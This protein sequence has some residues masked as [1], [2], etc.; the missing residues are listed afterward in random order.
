M[1]SNIEKYIS[2][3]LV[4]KFLL[5]CNPDRSVERAI[6]VC[7]KR[8]RRPNAQEVVYLTVVEPVSEDTASNWKFVLAPNGPMKHISV[9]ELAKDFIENLNTL[10][11]LAEAEGAPLAEDMKRGVFL[12][13]A[14]RRTPL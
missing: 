1:A 7:H 6:Y 4:F 5:L 11:A 10:A 2:A 3:A 12:R 13:G 14:H 9:F 8:T